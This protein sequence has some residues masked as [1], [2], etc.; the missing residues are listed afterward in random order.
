MN[1]ATKYK[2]KLLGIQV[3]LIVMGLYFPVSNDDD[4][5]GTFMK[6]YIVFVPFLS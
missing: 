4:Y 1:A 2:C 5:D 6:S 3:N